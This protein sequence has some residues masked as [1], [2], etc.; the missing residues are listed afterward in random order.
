[1]ALGMGRFPVAGVANY[2]DDFLF[3]RFNP[4]YRPHQ[5]NDIFAAA[6]TPVRASEDGTVRFT[7]GGI[8]GKAYYLTTGGGTYYFGCHMSA[9]ADLPSGSSV[10][11]GQIVGFVGDTGDAAGGAPHL[12]FEI[13]PGGGGAVNPKSILDGWLDEALA[14]VASIVASYQQV[15]LPKAISYAGTLRRFD[16]PLSGGSGIATLLAD[17]SSNPG[18]RRLSELRASRSMTSDSSKAD[19]AI[20]EAWHDADRTSQ[21]LLSLVTPLALENTLARNS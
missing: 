21:S 8:S 4:E 6:G 20:A 5:G 2:G 7:E 1:A 13:H 12:H 16:E 3:P 9:F 19:A 17:S 14:N 18:V 10:S 15:G 11:Q